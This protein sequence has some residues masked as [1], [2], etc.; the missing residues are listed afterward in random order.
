MNAERAEVRAFPRATATVMAMYWM[1][2]RQLCGGTGS[3]D[4]DA[5]GIC[6]D[7]DNCTDI[8]SHEFCR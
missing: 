7:I 4:V 5:D 2:D 6:D 8:T 3:C 1:P